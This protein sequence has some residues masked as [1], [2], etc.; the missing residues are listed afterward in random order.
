MQSM[1]VMKAAR[2]TVLSSFLFGALFTI[3][4]CSNDD[5]SS[6]ADPHADHDHSHDH[7]DH[8]HDHD[9]HTHESDSSD[10]VDTYSNILG[11]VT[12]LKDESNPMSAFK[13]RHVH[14]PEFKTLSGEVHVNKN[15]VPGMAAMEMEFPPAK[16]LDLSDFKVG[17]K[18]RFEF[19]VYIGKSM[20]WNLTE[21]EK[22]DPDTEIDYTNKIP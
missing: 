21:I 7:A 15:G 19:K 10:R 22:I 20:Y 8:D 9:G 16:G 3:P 6:T 18:V 13:I 17:D 1:L 4:A 12:Q 11:Q 5:S 14:I 2:M